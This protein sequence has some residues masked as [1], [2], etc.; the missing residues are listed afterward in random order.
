MIDGALGGGGTYLGM[1]FSKN[2]GPTNVNPRS[3]SPQVLS[4][5]AVA[6]LAISCASVGNNF[7]ESKIS[8]IKK[9][10]TTEADLLKMFGQPENRTM[11]SD[12]GLTLTWMYAESAVKGESFIPYAGTFLG[13][14][15]SKNKSLSA[16]LTNSVVESFTYSGGGTESRNMTQSTPSN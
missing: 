15:R 16:V 14:A 10:Q 7:D 13:G 9:G 8:E 5:L 3:H 4:L 12:S 1:F 6:F 2:S 11:N